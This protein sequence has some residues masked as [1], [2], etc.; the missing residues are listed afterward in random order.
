MTDATATT[1]L[2]A[3]SDAVADL[4]IVLVHGIGDQREGE[5][6]L[7][8]GEPI[9]EYL[10]RTVTQARAHRLDWVQLS[11]AVLLPSKRR[12]TQPAWAR[13]DLRVP[14]R[15]TDA[16]GIEYTDLQNQRWLM[17][18]AWWGEQVIAPAPLTLI[19][20]LMTRGPWV[21]LLHIMERS[22]SYRTLTVADLP[23]WLARR[24]P[25]F[26]K[27]GFTPMTGGDTVA[28]RV[29]RLLLVGLGLL[30]VWVPLTALMQ[31][32]L[33][34]LALL[35]LVPL[36]R[37]GRAVG[38]F[39][40]RVSGVLGDS[41]VL[42]QQEAQRAAIVARVRD[43]L[44]HTQQRCAKLAVIAHSQG[45]AVVYDALRSGAPKPALLLTF[46]SGLAK[47]EML[48][49][50]ERLSRSSLSATGWAVPLGLTAFLVWLRHRADIEATLAVP[51]WAIGFAALLCFGFGVV[52]I[53]NA[54]RLLEAQRDAEARADLRL[55]QRWIDVCATNDPVPHASLRDSL[56]RP[57]IKVRN[58]MNR[59]SFVS[60]H[61]SYFDNRAEFV[62]LVAQAL[63]AT[64]QLH[65]TPPGHAR[66]LRKARRH[67]VASVHL[68][69]WTRWVCA[70]AVPAI[71]VLFWPGLHA[72]GATWLQS[73]ADSVPGK[74]LDL[75]HSLR[76]FSAWT[77]ALSGLDIA[78]ADS[79]ALLAVFA[80]A[81]LTWLWRHCFAPMWRW[82]D[83]VLIDDA[84]NA[85]DTL[86]KWG[87][88]LL[89]PF[90][91]LLGLLPVL[92]AALRLN[93]YSIEEALLSTLSVTVSLLIITVIITAL[94]VE[95]VKRLRRWRRT[96]LRVLAVLRRATDPRAGWQRFTNV[97][98]L[99]WFVLTAA[100]FGI[101]RLE[102]AGSL[103][104][105]LVVPG[106]FAALALLLGARLLR[107]LQLRRWGRAAIAGVAAA[108][109]ACASLPWWL[110]MAGDFEHHG[111]LGSMCTLMVAWAMYAVLRRR[112][113]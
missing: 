11:D 5:T 101:S 27:R 86:G 73:L 90:L 99:V 75:R 38:A 35:A 21:S 16:E 95:V 98:V 82:W 7:A 79:M 9:V 83:R 71:A 20:W 12:D 104:E 106:G 45:T 48:R 78:D 54:R 70:L 50:A 29:V 58:V 111:V 25:E 8:F 10:R 76:S 18:E 96:R 39:L 85:T 77:R 14:Q 103:F 47:L 59:S 102:Q 22:R 63:A 51:A 100:A 3:S 110:G 2:Q 65:L 49:I 46:G 81:A 4:G 33:A 13:I 69:A 34:L 97:V 36:P 17:T 32:A 31:A 89:A 23:P 55:A 53:S 60:D 93:G 37:I 64:A 57:E 105:R 61:T 30:L 26:V 68:L 52:A 84:L 74:D 67:H 92:L 56:A 72:D 94:G 91:I 6:L 80:G 113:A 88:Y 24:L 62:P 42:V 107:L 44:A 66:Q 40:L 19:G 112:G 15:R 108:L 43:V 87:S 28:G 1:D 109:T 41:Y